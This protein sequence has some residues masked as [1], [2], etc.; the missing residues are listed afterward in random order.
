MKRQPRT[1]TAQA[2][3][4]PCMY[5]GCNKPLS[6]LP[7]AQPK[8]T[9]WGSWGFGGLGT[10]STNSSNNNRNNSN[11]SSSSSQGGE[12]SWWGSYLAVAE[13][14]GYATAAGWLLVQGTSSLLSG[15]SAPTPAAAVAAT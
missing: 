15:E 10:T 2:L 14:Q 3:P 9:G 11:S 5:Y 8:A 1:S 4:A 6:Q 7:L 12:G 13:Q